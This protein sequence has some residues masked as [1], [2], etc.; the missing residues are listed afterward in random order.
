MSIAAKQAE[1]QVGILRSGELALNFIHP[2]LISKGN[3]ESAEITV[4]VGKTRAEL[5]G[6]EII[7]SQAGISLLRS[8]EIKFI[9][10]HPSKDGF[11]I[12]NVLIGIGFHWEQK[13]DQLFPGTLLLSHMDGEIQA[14]NQVLLEKYLASVISSE[15]S[16]DSF[17]AL[18]KAHAIISRSW[19]LAQVEKRD[20]LLDS[21]DTY[22]SLKNEKN[23][24]IRWYDRED[25]KG[26][27]VCA[28]DHCQR[29]Q[30]ITRAGNPQVLKAVEE[31]SGEVLEYQGEI[32][33][34]RFSKCCGGVVEAF[35]HCWEN[36]S[37]P[38][39]VRVDDNPPGAKV[40]VSDLKLE[41]NARAFILSSPDAFCNTIDPGLLKKVLNDYDHSA[42][43]Y[44]WEVRYTQQ[45]LAEL[46]RKKSGMDFGAILD[47]EPVERGESGR[48]VKLQIVGSKKT[49]IIGKELE[50]RRWLSPSHLYSAAFIPEALNIKDGVPGAFLLR[51]AG[52]GH[53]VGL[54]QIGAAVMAQKGYKHEE[55]LKHYFK[56]AMINK[57][58]E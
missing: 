33:D 38:Y 5:Q 35:Q 6:G 7:L 50:I 2:Y 55:I 32:C 12:S 52:W 26:F 9:P 58:Y 44:R 43:F 28:D 56:N 21:E 51:G 14:I 24:F 4:L 53:G 37:F 46:I 54:C 1:I 34:A 57:R 16:G 8:Q 30:G 42:Q 47:L 45:E 18:L 20:K 49:L 10:Q 15:M 25:H 39:L 13:Q 36:R 23:E 11:Q 27:D 48:L 31:T 29:Y 22:H 17:P 3:S 41:K 19:L 40:N